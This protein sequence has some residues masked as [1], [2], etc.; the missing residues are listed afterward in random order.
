MGCTICGS[1]EMSSSFEAREMMMGLK[2]SFSYVQCLNCK[3][4]QIS[5]I[6]ND[7]STYYAEN[8]YSLQ[9]SEPAGF[10]ERVIKRFRDQYAVLD[11]SYLGKLIYQR[12]PKINLRSL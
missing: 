3:S 1:D 5:T 11:N 8:Y 7:L 12:Y 10:I 2:D 9:D 4:L 6:P